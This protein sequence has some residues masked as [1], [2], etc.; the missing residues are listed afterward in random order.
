MRSK[1]NY[2]GKIQGKILKNT[3]LNLIKNIINLL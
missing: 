2:I 1:I 3:Y